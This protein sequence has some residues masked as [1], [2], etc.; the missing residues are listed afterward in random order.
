MYFGI[1]IIRGNKC[2]VFVI[3]VSF[4]VINKICIEYIYV[5]L[6]G[7]WLLLFIYGFFMYSMKL[8]GYL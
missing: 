4:C 1:I 5:F 7:S 3:N 2:N 6:G 8:G